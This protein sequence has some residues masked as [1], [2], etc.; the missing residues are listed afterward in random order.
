MNV[1]WK[2]CKRSLMK[3]K[4]R[5]IITIIG[6]AFATALITAVACM[7]TSFLK[8][9]TEYLK[10]SG[11]WHSVYQAVSKENLKYFENNQAIEGA[12]YV[13]RNGY[14]IIEREGETQKEQLKTVK[15]PYYLELLAPEQEFYEHKKIVVKKGRLPEKE[16]EILLSSALRTDEGEDIQIGDVITVKIG[17]RAI[18]DQLIELG[19]DL[20]Q[21]EQLFIRDKKTFVVVGFFAGGRESTM[22]GYRSG[23]GK[24]TYSAYYYD[25]EPMDYIDV[26]VRF[27]KEGLK[28]RTEVESAI[29]GISPELFQRMYVK[30]KHVSQ[31]EMSRATKVAKGYRDNTMLAF[32]EYPIG[33]TD[34]FYGLLGLLALG[35]LFVVYAGVFCINNSFDLSFTERVRFYGMLVSVGMTKRQKRK[36]VWLEALYIGGIGIPIGIALGCLFT[37]GL[38]AIVNLSISILMK[39]LGFQMVFQASALGICAASLI[40]ALM[41]FLSAMES[42]VRASRIMPITAIRMNDV[43]ASKQPKKKSKEK[44]KKKKTPFY[45]KKIFGACGNVAFQNYKRSKLKYRATITT[46]AVSVAM[47]VGLSFIQMLF[48]VK[49]NTI[50]K[51]FGSDWQLTVYSGRENYAELLEMSKLSGVTKSQ[52]SSMEYVRTDD[53]AIPILPEID[54]QYPGII[55]LAFLDDASFSRL[56]KEVG[57]DPEKAQGK[58][59]VDCYVCT[60]WHFQGQTLREE[61]DKVAEFEPG[62]ILNIYKVYREGKSDEYPLEIVC[63]YD[64]APVQISGS[65]QTITIYVPL[66]YKLEHYDFFTSGY[67][68]SFLCDDAI[69]LENTIED[70]SLTNLSINNIDYEYKSNRFTKTMVIAALCG[71]I[72]VIFLIGVTNIINAV[73]TNMELR[74]PEYAKL[75]ALGMTEKQFRGMLSLEGIFIAGKGLVYGLLIGYAIS[76]A[77]YRFFWEVDDKNFTFGYRIPVGESLLAILIVSVMMFLVLRYSRKRISKKNLIETIRSENI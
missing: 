3:N 35:Y 49:E 1:L 45:V 10:Q 22:I 59:I 56:C 72:C 32:V 71:F 4:S 68:E 17:D 75:K 29:L 67:V 57:I 20:Q 51:N 14:G 23:S 15:V 40:S 74:A 39:N 33:K 28:R 61:Y 54:V 31:D 70:M 18:G 6:V 73:S 16:G 69:A 30:Y 77:L 13:K 42:A 76:Y 60:E 8:S 27:T 41:V 34:A 36:L 12:W 25:P 53:D 48:E 63:Q 55:C 65:N 66:S 64:K 37:V 11:D 24:I 19:S 38:V 52:I 47:L 26:Y 7:G 50:Q 21:E 46:I 9:E 44:E 2:C 62:T 58:G 43:I 5:T